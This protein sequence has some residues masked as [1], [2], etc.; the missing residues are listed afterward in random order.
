LLCWQAHEYLGIG[1][2]AVSFMNRQRF[3]NH[4]NVENYIEDMLADRPQRIEVLETMT[5]HQ[6]VV[7]AIIL[8][9]RLTGGIKRGEFRERFGMDIMEEY[10]D[11]IK[12]C[13]AQ[14]LLE[15]E[16]DRIYLEKRAYFLS[17]QVFNQFMA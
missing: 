7:D 9:L 16:N 3:L 13:Q 4:A 12:T 2:G 10:R 5:P 14:G 17:N 1:C 6:L 8:G 15:T 11:I